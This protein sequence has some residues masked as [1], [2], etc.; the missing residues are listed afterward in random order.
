MNVWCTFIAYVYI[1]YIHDTFMNMKYY[2][3]AE[4]I[5]IWH[6]YNTLCTYAGKLSTCRLH[7]SLYSSM[8]ETNIAMFYYFSM[9]TGNAAT[10]P[11]INYLS[12]ENAVM[13]Q[14]YKTWLFL[15][16]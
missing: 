15:L 11:H 3:H 16:C 6:V 13:S 8:N 5:L 12:T 1:V 4:C 14:I 2:V 10:W 7:Y 9:E